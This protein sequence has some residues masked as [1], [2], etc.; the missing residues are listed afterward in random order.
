MHQNVIDKVLENEIIND[1]I[2]TKK[3]D[4][5]QFIDKNIKN[6]NKSDDEFVNLF[7]DINS[8]VLEKVLSETKEK[9]KK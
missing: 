7:E 9:K 5:I 8:F 1:N 4:W 2:N 6:K 3:D